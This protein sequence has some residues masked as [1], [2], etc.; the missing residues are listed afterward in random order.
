MEVK[1]K[2]EMS[3]VDL[4]TCTT[5]SSELERC[6]KHLRYCCSRS[7]GKCLKSSS[8]SHYLRVIINKI[9][10]CNEY[11]FYIKFINLSKHQY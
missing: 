11:I 2:R 5:S 9:D 1:E 7:S 6:D 10:S 8:M 3:D 4:Y